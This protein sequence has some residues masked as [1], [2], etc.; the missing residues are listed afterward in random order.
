MDTMSPAQR[1]RMSMAFARIK[2]LHER[3]DHTTDP[4]AQQRLSDES[5]TVAAVWETYYPAD[6]QRLWWTDFAAQRDADRADRADLVAERD[7]LAA[8]VDQLTWERDEAGAEIE[9]ALADRAELAGQLAAALDER[10]RLA[11]VNRELAVALDDAL[12]I[13]SEHALDAAH[14]RLAVAQVRYCQAPARPPAGQAA[15][16]VMQA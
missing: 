1:E 12:D 2:A 7:A 13:A 9:A 10:D 11:H 3:M 4:Q 8:Q 16:A 14:E 15:R 5:A 6:W